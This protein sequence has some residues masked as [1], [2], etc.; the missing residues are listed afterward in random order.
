MISL[1]GNVPLFPFLY[2][3]FKNNSP[4]SLYFVSTIVHGIGYICIAFP[5]SS[6]TI[7]INALLFR[8]SCVATFS[9]ICCAVIYGFGSDNKKRMFA[10]GLTFSPPAG[11]SRMCF[12]VSFPIAFTFGRMHALTMSL[13][14][15]FPFHA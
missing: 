11:S 13:S 12:P 15:N 5:F 9:C 6:R 7:N 4:V 1:Y 8:Q 2:W 3:N 10:S 14:Y